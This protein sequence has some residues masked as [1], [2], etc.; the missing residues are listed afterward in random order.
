MAKWTRPDIIFRFPVFQ[1]IPYLQ[2]LTETLCITAISH[3]DL[4]MLLP[5]LIVLFKR[6]SICLPFHIEAIESLG[7]LP[8]A[9]LHSSRHVYAFD[10]LVI[11]A[12]IFFYS[13]NTLVQERS[14]KIVE[15]AM[16]GFIHTLSDYV[17]STMRK[18]RAFEMLSSSNQ[19]L[20]RPWACDSWSMTSG[21]RPNAVHQETDGIR[22]RLLGLLWVGRDFHS[23]ESR[24]LDG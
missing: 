7:W 22:F 2:R 16:T 24:H 1:E 14:S 21:N 8:L 12:A 23:R 6:N 10:A 3:E 20:L 13:P 18:T 17:R 9:F 19:A 11:M 5:S 15:H 4:R